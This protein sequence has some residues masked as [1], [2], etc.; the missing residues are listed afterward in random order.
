[1]RKLDKKVCM[2][3]GGDKGNLYKRC[4]ACK[5]IW[6]KARRRQRNVEIFGARVKCHN[7]GDE[8]IRAGRRRKNKPM[9]CDKAECQLADPRKKKPIKI[10]P[11]ER[12]NMR[13]L[14]LG[15]IRGG[16]TGLRIEEQEWN[17]LDE[18]VNRTIGL[19]MVRNKNCSSCRWYGLCSEAVKVGLPI[20]CEAWDDRDREVYEKSEAHDTMRVIMERAL[21]Y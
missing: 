16:M 11:D 5:V 6:D 4:A 18:A 1:M 13:E 17:A 15:T 2:D 21:A 19:P 8:V 10:E 14:E 7:C 12:L 20:L 3:C 9:F